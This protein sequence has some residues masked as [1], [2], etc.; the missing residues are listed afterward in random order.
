M[1]ESSKMGRKMGKGSLFGL[2]GTKHG[3]LFMFKREGMVLVGE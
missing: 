3:L 2:T 1:K